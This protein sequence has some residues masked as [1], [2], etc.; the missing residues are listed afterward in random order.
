[1]SVSVLSV[2]AGLSTYVNGRIHGEKPVCTSVVV[3]HDPCT[4]FVGHMST[5]SPLAFD[6]SSHKPFKLL[7]CIHNDQ[8]Y[9]SNTKLQKY[10]PGS[11]LVVDCHFIR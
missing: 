4:K 5:R 11:A 1:M 9:V 6:V 3:D 10:V 8:N 7:P 2:G